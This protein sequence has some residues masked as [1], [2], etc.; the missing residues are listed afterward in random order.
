MSGTAVS[1]FEKFTLALRRLFS[2]GSEEAASADA[3]PQAAALLLSEV[4][5]VDHDVK[6]IDLAAAREGLQQLFP[7]DS[8]K[9]AAMLEA[10][11]RL[12]NRPTSY[13]AIVNL[14]NRELSA[15]QKIDL[16]EQMWRVAQIDQ[17]IDMYED[18]LVRK[19]SDLLYVPHR[20]FIAAKHRAAKGAG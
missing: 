4:A 14:L 12:E 19:I 10:A 15:Q 13:H 1:A 9:S 2:A 8:E 3:V 5:R 18:H 11:G 6:E 20:E 17:E 7:M 16:I